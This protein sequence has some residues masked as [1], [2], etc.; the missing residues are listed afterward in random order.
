MQ[1]VAVQ[2]RLEP[3]DLRIAVGE[4]VA[5]LGASGAGKTTLLSLANGSLLPDQGQVEWRGQPIRTLPRRLRREIG[6]LWQDLRLIEEL[7]VS[8][9]VNAGALGRHSLLWALRNLMQ[10]LERRECLDVV[11]AAGL[12]PDLMDTAVNRLSGGQRQRVA[13]ARLLRQQPLLVLADEPLSA[14][15]PVLAET[16]LNGL[17]NQAGCLVSLHRPDLVHR[18][19]RVIGLRQGRLVLDVSTGDVTSDAIAWLYQSL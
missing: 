3:L 7:T 6:T 17:L 16:V 15:D 9:N 12:E 14:L 10:P 11:T 1:Q 8:R 5:L 19:D 18:F 2:G 13:L 4:R